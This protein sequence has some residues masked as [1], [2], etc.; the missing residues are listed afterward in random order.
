MFS[1]GLIDLYSAINQNVMPTVCGA[2]TEDIGAFAV[3]F[4]DAEL[5]YLTYEVPLILD[6]HSALPEFESIVILTTG[7]QGRPALL[8]GP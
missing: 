6:I 1:L 4:P 5:L 3:P 2:T 8:A 7:V